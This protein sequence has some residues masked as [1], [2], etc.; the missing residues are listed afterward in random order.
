[1]DVT[2]TDDVDK[3]MPYTYFMAK[4]ALKCS[5]AVTFTKEEYERMKTHKWEIVH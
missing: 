1:M 4:Y 3:A 2:G 5:K